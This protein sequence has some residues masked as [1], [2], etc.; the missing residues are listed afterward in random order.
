MCPT[1][2]FIDR[3][4]AKFN[5]AMTFQKDYAAIISYMWEIDTAYSSYLENPDADSYEVLRKL[6]LEDISDES[7]MKER[8]R[9]IK[10]LA[11][12]DKSNKFRQQYLGDT[13]EDEV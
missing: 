2:A 12:V 8:D 9:L 5:N 3:A 6:G 11:K 10:R 7:T 1:Y 13:D 4:N